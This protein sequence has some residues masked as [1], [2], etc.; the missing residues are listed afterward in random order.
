MLLRAGAENAGI[1]RCRQQVSRRHRPHRNG[2]KRKIAELV[3]HTTRIVSPHVWLTAKTSSIQPYVNTIEKET[4]ST[5]FVVASDIF[6]ARDVAASN[7]DH[8]FL[9]SRARYF[10]FAIQ[11]RQTSITTFVFLSN[12]MFHMTITLRSSVRC[13]STSA[14]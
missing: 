4:Q 2:L 10:P 7:N 3:T 8:N 13:L 1:C 9:R 14:R 6:F 12:E 5:F 11:L